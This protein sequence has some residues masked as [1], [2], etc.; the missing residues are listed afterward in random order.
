MRRLALCNLACIDYGVADTPPLGADVTF[1]CSSA[2]N[3]V[4]RDFFRTN[5]TVT[6]K[7]LRAGHGLKRTSLADFANS[8]ARMAR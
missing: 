4:V 3:R 2:A 5:A 7:H 6:D 8:L 1:V